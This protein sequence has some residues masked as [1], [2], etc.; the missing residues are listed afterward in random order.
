MTLQEKQYL[1]SNKYK[2]FLLEG[3]SFD[4]PSEAMTDKNLFT[5]QFFKPDAE[6]DRILRLVL[7]QYLL[8]GYIS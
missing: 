2:Q 3:I 6:R 4:M 7:D 5:Q 8:G 1:N